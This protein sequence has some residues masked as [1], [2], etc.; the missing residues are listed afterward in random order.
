MIL[1][2]GELSLGALSCELG[3]LIEERDI[4]SGTAR[5]DVDIASR[6]RALRAGGGI[7]HAIRARVQA[8]AR[9]LR[10]IAGVE[11]GRTDL[12]R[13]GLLVALAYPERVARRRGESPGKFQMVN[14][15]GAIL[16]E[17]SVMGREEFIAVADVDGIGTEVRIFRA[18]HVTREDLTG[19]FGGTIV[20][21]EQVFWDRPLEA[22]V[23]RHVRRLG[24]ITLEEQASPARGDSAREA[25]LD[26]VR[27]MG[28][29]ALPWER[30][31]ESVRTRSEWLRTHALVS[32]EWPDLSDSHLLDTLPGW[33]GPFLGGVTRR[34]HLAN[35]DMGSILR[36]FF[37]AGQWNDLAHLAP[38]TITVPTGSKARL[39]YA[40][41][42]IPVLSVRLQEMFGQTDTPLIA[43]GRV[44]VLIHLLSPA[45]RPLAVTRDL[46]SFWSNAYREVRSEMRG[47]YPKHVWP[48][49][50]LGA[51]PTR[52]TTKPPHREH[53]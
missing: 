11:G 43:G 5:G 22:V 12:S 49:D 44:G 48:E 51:K 30:G 6:V 20:D 15:A 1:R 42:D 40:S 10:T 36:V 46:G 45:G 8:E 32:G 52:K 37:T 53:D 7:G 4:L 17:G 25:M 2:G 28:L 3:A 33:L 29:G 35:L 34:S 50:P 23:S 47:R 26:G 13:L 24:A 31:S 9:R 41:G 39:D 14:G 19:E 38:E 21:E 18:A 27:L 16:P